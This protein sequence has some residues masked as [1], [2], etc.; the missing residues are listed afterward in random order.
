MALIYNEPLKHADA[1]VVLEGD[2][3]HR[4]PF[5]VSLYHEGWAPYI[6]LSGGLNAPKQG[7]VPIKTMANQLKKLGIPEKAI[8]LEST[9]LH[10]RAQA[11]EIEKI[12]REHHWKRMILVAS[13]YHQ[14]RA[15]L[16]FLKVFKEKKCSIRIVN[17]PVRDLPWFKKTAW[18]I[19]AD[20]LLE[21]MKKIETYR[22]KGHVASWADGIAYFKK[23]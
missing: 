11:E 6:V 19:R 23:K 14:P 4:L 7:S 5:A 3:Y 9:S 2:G 10:T 20:L 15:F 16:T 13:H 18:G 22:A 17:A 1:I 21:E 8:I 12:G